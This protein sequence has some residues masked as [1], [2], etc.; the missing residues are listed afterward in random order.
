MCKKFNL[1]EVIKD[2]VLVNVD[3][4]CPFCKGDD[5]F[6]NSKEND[7][8]T[9]IVNDHKP[10]FAKIIGKVE[11]E[12][13]EMNK[14]ETDKKVILKREKDCVIINKE[15]KTVEFLSVSYTFDEVLKVAHEIAETF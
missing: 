10:E 8:V 7:I 12:W 11:K 4:P 2:S 14:T 9:H 3:D 1:D 15:D 6:I 13:G 5:K